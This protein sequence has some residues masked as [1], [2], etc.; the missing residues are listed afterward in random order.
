[1]GRLILAALMMIMQVFMVIQ[2][3]DFLA[4]Q[5]IT[6]FIQK[7]VGGLT[8]SMLMIRMT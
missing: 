2:S 6:G 3:V 1:L 8:P 7:M 5:M 4:K